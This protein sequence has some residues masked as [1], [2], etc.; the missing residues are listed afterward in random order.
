MTDWIANSSGHTLTAGDMT[1]ST[2]NQSDRGCG[3]CWH[4]QVE[5][6]Y[7]MDQIA[8]GGGLTI[9]DEA[10]AKAVE[11]AR[12]YCNSV[13]AALAPAGSPQQ[14][15]ESC[16]YV[17]EPGETLVGSDDVAVVLVFRDGRP[18]KII[19]PDG[20]VEPFVHPKRTGNG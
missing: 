19:F 10:K 20:R 3:W 5:H 17:P 15:I 11:F 7:G 16:G 8:C 2:T 4:V 6:T 18:I 9:E 12:S 1:L 13:L 14:Q